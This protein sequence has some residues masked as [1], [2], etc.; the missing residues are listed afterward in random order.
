M[1]SRSDDQMRR[2]LP[3]S[4]W[5]DSDQMLWHELLRPVS[6]LDENR[7]NASRWR[8]ATVHKNR[9]GYGR[10][11]NYLG[12]AGADLNTCPEDRVTIGSVNRY[13]ETLRSQE[14]APYTQYT[15]I[16]ELLSVM[17]AI[18]PVRDWSWLKRKVNLLHQLAQE[19]HDLEL[20]PI[21]A[22]EIAAKARQALDDLI[23]SQ[24][25]LKFHGAVAYRNWLM[26]SFL[27]LLPLRLKNFAALSL[28][29]EVRLKESGS[30]IRIPGR[31]TKTGRAIRAP[32]PS[33]LSSHLQHYK[34]QVRPLLLRAGNTD[35]MWINWTGGEMSEHAVYMRLTEFTK[36]N[37]GH[38]INPHTFRHITATSISL[39]NPEEIDTARALLGHS[40]CKTTQQ[41]YIAADSIKASKRH[42]AI[43]SRLRKRLLSTGLGLEIPSVEP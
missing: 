14:C 40:S 10:W 35:R 18:S 30:E 22:P 7:S 19:S 32:I 37:F 28:G 39:L 23:R 4:D 36:A 34:D 27:I 13:I 20:P 43:I 16:A 9:R 3:V 29:K 17:L 42:A 11:L 21:L 5:P 6:L 26:V 41:H 25:K 31:D 2:C 33:S 8:S 12:Y 15:R 38:R 24:G 1:M